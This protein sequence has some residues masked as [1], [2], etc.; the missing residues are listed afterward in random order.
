MS[1][2]KVIVNGACGKVGKEV[3]KA[4]LKESSLELVGAVDITGAGS[5]IGEL[6]GIGKSGVKVT[7]DLAKTINDTKADVV[8]DFTIPK[9]IMGSIK[10]ATSAKANVVVGTTGISESDLKEISSLCKQNGVNVLVAPNF[11]IGAV[12]MMKFASE[13]IKHMPKAEIIELHH[14]QKLDAPSGTSIK[15][16]E[17]MKKASGIKDIPIHSVRLPGFVAHQE[18]IFGGLGQTLTIRH[19]SISRESFMPGVILAIKKIKDIKGLVY[20]LEYLL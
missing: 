11:A 5:D 1:K 8:V 6:A 15:T 12:L 7:G 13:A 17:M 9:T 19:D 20:G 16:A 18:V 10:A 2:I 3:V 4:V 14:D